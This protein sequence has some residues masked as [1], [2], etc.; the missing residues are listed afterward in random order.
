MEQDIQTITFHGNHIL[1]VEKGG[2]QYVAMKPLCES[3]GLTWG[4][5]YNRVKRNPILNP[6]VFIMKI[7]AEDGKNREMQMSKNNLLTN[8]QRMGYLPSF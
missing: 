3:I 4:S 2:I 1:S 5:Q 7:V 6:T 8:Q